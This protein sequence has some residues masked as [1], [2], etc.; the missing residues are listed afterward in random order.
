M[1]WI[2]NTSFRNIQIGYHFDP[3]P[4]SM[5][6]QITDP[7]GYVPIPKYKFKIVRHFEFCDADERNTEVPHEALCTAEQGRE[8]YELLRHAIDN[9]MN[10]IVHCHAGLCRS[11]AVAEVGIIMGLQDT[12]VE[13][14]PNVLV[15]KQILQWHHG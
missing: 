3:G 6:I 2:E 14:I 13:R 4:N 15:K 9:R 11:G 1:Q 5:L 10:V 12:E 8:I 7:A